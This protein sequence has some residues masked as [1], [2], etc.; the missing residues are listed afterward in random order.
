VIEKMEKIEKTI[1]DNTPSQFSNSL[2]YQTFE[3]KLAALLLAE[4]PE[5]TF[6]VD[7]NSNSL[8]KTIVITFPKEYKDTIANLEK[9]FI[10][11]QA[12][13]NIYAYNKALNLI[14]DRLRGCDEE[15]GKEISGLYARLRK[16]GTP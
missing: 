3:L 13:A 14:R 4:I 1:R 10:N 15:K 2:K 9:D 7:K 8:R 5:A 12:V 11:K 6:R 16:A